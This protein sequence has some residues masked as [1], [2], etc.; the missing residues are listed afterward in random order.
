MDKLAS[1]FTDIFTGDRLIRMIFSDRRKKSQECRKVLIRP[2]CI[3]GQQMYQAEY[4]FEKKVTHENL[5]SEE[6]VRCSLSLIAE[7][8][9]QINIFLEGEDIQILAAKPERPRITRKSGTKQPACLEH[10]KQKNYIIP[11]GE[12][13]DFLIRLGV[14]DRS[15]RVLKKHYGKFRQIN[16]YLEIVEDVFPLLPVYPDGRPL[17]IIDFGCGK[18][19]LPSPFTII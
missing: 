13:C 19:Y 11:D 6:T 8:F 17:R 9:Q 16:R 4:T 3:G 10:N 5:S 14:M 15:G 2:V 18:A 7:Q 12:P 1:V